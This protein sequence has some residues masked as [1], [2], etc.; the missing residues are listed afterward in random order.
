[1]LE[2]LELRLRLD[3]NSSVAGLVLIPSNTTACFVFAH[4]AGAGME[5]R[6][7]ADAAEGLA[8]RGVATVRY[9]FPYMQAGNKRPDRPEVAHV[10]VFAAVAEAALRFP[11][12][13][14][15]AGGKSFGGRMT[16]QAQAASPMPGLGGLAFFGFPLHPAG[17]PSV[18]RADH[19]NAI[20]IPTLFLQGTADKLAEVTLIKQTTETLGPTTKLHL[21]KD[22]DHSFH[23]PKRSGRTDT[24]VLDEVLDVFADWACALPIKATATTQA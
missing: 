13:R 12:V 20:H 18:T 6:F 5:H 4:G 1:M 7:M 8:I 19:L 15:I 14:L 10:A 17:K 2:R 24:D 21:V 22:A 23:V 16:S 9:Q 3:A 11:G